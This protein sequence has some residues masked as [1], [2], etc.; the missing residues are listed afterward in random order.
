[1]APTQQE[2]E[3]RELAEASRE[4]DWQGASFIKELF[5]GRFRPD[6]M[7]P[8][9][10]DEPDR[11]EF[12]EFMEELKTFLKE[13][14]D[15]VEIDRT[16]EYPEEVVQGLRELGAFGI[17]IPKEYGG[18]GLTHPEYVRVMQLLGAYDANVTALL[19]AH[20]A[21]GVPQ[22]VKLF[23]DEALKQEYL[24]RCAK[25]AISAF[26]LTEPAVGS[27]PAR[28]E[29][30]A[31]LSDDGEHWILNGTKLWC[32]NGTLAELLVVMARNPAT[33]RINAYV[34]ETAWE[35]VEIEHRCRFMGLKALAN[36]VVSFTD[37]KVPKENLIG[38]DGMGLKIA[39]V[40]LNTGRLTLPAGTAGGVKVMLEACRKWCEARIQWGVPVGKHEA[41]AHKMA[42][43]ASNAFAMESLAFLLGDLADRE[44][45]DIR[46]EAAAAKEWNTVTCWRSVDDALQIRGGRGYETEQSLK[47]RG[48][49]AIGIERAM[50]DVRINLIFEGS[51]EIMHLFMAREAVDKHLA[52]AG[53]L[54]DHKATFGQK[55][56]A[57][58]RIGLFYAWWYPTRWLGWGLWPRYSAYG[59]LAKHVRFADRSSR[60]LARSV[61]HGMAI[62]QAKL[63]RKQMFLFRAVDV[64]MELF[65]MTAVCARAKRMRLE[66]LEG[67]ESAQRL[68]DTFCK[69]ARRRVK[70]SLKG[71][72]ANDDDLK[73]SVGKEILTGTHAWLERGTLGVPYTAE[74]L[75]P[76][77]VTEIRERRAKT[78]EEAHGEAGAE[79]KPSKPLEVE[80]AEAQEE[81]SASA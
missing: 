5:L 14:V 71:M 38:G 47:D 53:P 75:R 52:V 9:P 50:R 62:Y 64:A 51:S 57:L 55:L 26:A 33:D 29:T 65:A 61:F 22:P 56:A 45:V 27:D 78:G 40:T 21:I 23:G 10:L 59:K 6:L 1:M 46:L 43:L 80:A 30:E 28:L 36:A 76:L 39:L 20:Q 70:A 41:I 17:K 24:P 42:D 81:A 60:K 74:E 67:H 32:T 3:S 54:V 18:L 12:L 35:G 37:V 19:S 77:T 25:G 11:P 68:A 66:G 34:V 69:G 63:E 44:G 15:P 79:E 2:L 73:H 49:A 8:F 58:P 13:K 48:E 72:W 31:R 4:K 16:G 7:D